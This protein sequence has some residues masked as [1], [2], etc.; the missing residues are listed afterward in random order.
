MVEREGWERNVPPH[1]GQLHN[2]AT[3]LP[4]QVGDDQTSQVDRSG[5]V[6]RNHLLHLV[7]GHV[8][9]RAEDAEAS[10]G[11]HHV[12]ALVIGEGLLND[13]THLHGIR[14][15]KLAHPQAVA[16]SGGEVIQLRRRAQGRCD[17]IPT[18]DRLC[19]QFA[20]HATRGTSNEPCGRHR[21][22]FLKINALLFSCT[23]KLDLLSNRAQPRAFTSTVP[24]PQR[25]HYAARYEVRCHVLYSDFRFPPRYT[26]L[27]F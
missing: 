21:S 24:I 10:V 18:S 27:S 22:S 1:A 16:V 11:H 6:G 26:L 15:I 5:Q 12:D 8:L 19:G 23:T 14:D 20:A 7:V 13:S 9:C 2:P 17:A 4:T 25:K 3:T